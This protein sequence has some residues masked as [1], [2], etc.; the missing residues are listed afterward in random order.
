M[1]GVLFVCTG[2]ICRSP[3]AEGIFQRLVDD[4][5]LTERFTIDSA[6]TH[7]YHIGDPPDERSQA[8][9]LR[10]GIDLSRLR[11]R[12]V[13]RRD[14][15]EFDYVL[16][17]DRGHVR[18]LEAICPRGN[19]HKIKLFLREYAPHLDLHDVPDPYY[20]GPKGFEHVLDLVE[21]ASQALLREIRR[22]HGL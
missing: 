12:E 11:A 10:R 9:A 14:L 5:G 20:G 4:E 19:E 1:I 7:G 2:N 22:E 21:D 17:M 8:A 16:A 15:I 13:H 3:T 6:G 18:H